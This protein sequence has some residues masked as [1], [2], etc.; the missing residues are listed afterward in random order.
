STTQPQ[1]CSLAFPSSFRLE[2]ATLVFVVLP[3][4]VSPKEYHVLAEDG[5]TPSCGNRQAAVVETGLEHGLEGNAL[6]RTA[7]T[8]VEA[9]RILSAVPICLG[10]QQLQP[11]LPGLLGGCGPQAGNHHARSLRQA[12][13]RGEGDGQRLLRRRWR[14]AVHASRTARHA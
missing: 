12:R 4:C 8:A 7:Q 3:A 11:A 5:Q 6:R 13:A 14:R 2:T 10:H 1:G 9:R